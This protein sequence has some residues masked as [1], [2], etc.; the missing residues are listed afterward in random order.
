MIKRILS[1]LTAY[2]DLCLQEAFPPVLDT[3]VDATSRQYHDRISRK[4]VF[5]PLDEISG[6]TIVRVIEGQ[7]EP[8]T[9]KPGTREHRAMLRQA[10]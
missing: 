3:H 4:G 2:L 7:G 8:P 5:R 10:F 9:P 1:N 6:V